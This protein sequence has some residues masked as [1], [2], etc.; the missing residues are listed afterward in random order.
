[1]SSV[2][3]TVRVE[4]LIL[5]F[6]RVRFLRPQR[7]NYMAP[8]NG[9]RRFFRERKLESNFKKVLKTSMLCLPPTLKMLSDNKMSLLDNLPVYVGAKIRVKVL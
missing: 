3:F 8:G 5:C 2:A 1:M 4:L 6:L 7:F 9:I